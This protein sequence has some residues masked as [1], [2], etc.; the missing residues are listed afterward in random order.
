MLID[1][2]LVTG[3]GYFPVCNPYS[4]EKVGETAIASQGDLQRALELARNTQCGHSPQQRATILK[5]LAGQLGQDKQSVARL[6]TSE[7]GLCIKDA[8]YEVNRVISAAEVAASVAVTI[9][10]DQTDNFQSEGAMGKAKLNVVSEPLDL[11]VGITPFNHPM[12]QVAHKVFPAIAAGAAIVL[13]PSPKTPLSAL[14]LG[15]LL[16]QAGLQKNLFNVVTTDDCPGAVRELVASPLVDMV[17][18]TGGSKVGVSIAQTMASSGNALKKYVPELGGCSSMIINDDADI[19]LAAK[20]ALNGCFA[21]SGQRCTAV[22]R[23]VVLDS[24]AEEFLEEFLRSARLIRMG[25]PFS[26]GVGMGT[27]VDEAAATMV[28]TRVQ[29]ALKDGAKLLLGH[30]RDGASY[31]PTVLDRVNLSSELVGEE[32]FGPVAPVIRAKDIDEAVRVAKLTCYGLA[33][34]I[35]CEDKGLALDVADEL[36]VG[37]FSWN[38]VPGYRTEAAPFGGFGLSGNGQKEGIILAAEGMRRIRTFYEHN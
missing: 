2:E 23:I 1:G 3:G 15:E 4:G 30:E 12:N 35:V 13:K 26:M 19:G 38:G 24:V 17:T 21:N 29:S 28:E 37:Q 34:A 11:V 32:T 36:R 25:D 31:P 6:I 20:L 9:D 7:S 33:G 5:T 18:F 16:M 22:R 8:L 14:R 10:A 27:L